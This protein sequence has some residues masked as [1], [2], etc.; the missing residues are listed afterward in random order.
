MRGLCICSD[1]IPKGTNLGATMWSLFSH[2]T[3]GQ[4]GIQYNVPLS[5]QAIRAILQ[6]NVK[7][8]CYKDHS[9]ESQGS[10]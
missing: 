4:R 8:V 7:L 10:E 1:C 2:C 3:T 9:H 6:G 5:E